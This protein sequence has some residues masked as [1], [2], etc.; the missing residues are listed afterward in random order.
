MPPED[1]AFPPGK[2]SLKREMSKRLW[3]VLVY[4]D[5]RRSFF[6]GFCVLLESDVAELEAVRSGSE[7]ILEIAAT[8]SRRNIAIRTTRST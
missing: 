7:R 8:P 4:Q 1:P 5:V 6:G 3:A 2:N